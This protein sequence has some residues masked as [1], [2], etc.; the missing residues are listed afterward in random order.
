MR[1][2][3]LGISLFSVTCLVAV[4][5]TGAEWVSRSYRSEDRPA[6]DGEPEGR[7]CYWYRQREYCGRYCYVE[8]NGR[9][10]C[11]ERERRAYPQAP[12][13]DG[14]VIIAPRDQHRMK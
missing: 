11:Q 13:P 5:A 14:Y 10:Y 12:E 7:G 2:I 4:E 6:F 3:S 8:A 1:R 9:R